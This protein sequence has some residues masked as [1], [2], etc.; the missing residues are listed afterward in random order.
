[1]KKITVD[2]KHHFKISFHRIHLNRNEILIPIFDDAKK[3]SVYFKAF[4]W[5]LPNEELTQQGIKILS[6]RISSMSK[7]NWRSAVRNTFEPV[8][9]KYA[10]EVATL[11]NHFNLTEWNKINNQLSKIPWFI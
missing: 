8:T 3:Q 1:M 2:I 11:T 5:S 6:Y 7:L 10:E 4:I 9:L